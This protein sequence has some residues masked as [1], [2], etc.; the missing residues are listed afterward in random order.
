MT[1]P[2]PVPVDLD[3]IAGIIDRYR[4]ATISRDE[5]QQLVD[6]LRAVIED[7]LGESES[8]L[9]GG[10]EVVRWRHVTTNRLDQAAVKDYLGAKYAEFLK[11]TQSRRFTIETPGGA[12]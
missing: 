1:S 12:A 5:M 9:I 11:P 6:E 7:R 3:D 10:R 8:G 2:E 4:I